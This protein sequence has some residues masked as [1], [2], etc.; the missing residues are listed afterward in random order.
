MINSKIM[1]SASQ[2]HDQ[3]RKIFFC[4]SQ[5]I[6]HDPGALDARDCMFNLDTDFGHLAIVLFLFGG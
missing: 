6:F 1:Q 5:N 4:I 2:H 3:I